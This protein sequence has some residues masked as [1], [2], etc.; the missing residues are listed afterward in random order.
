MP[1][2]HVYFHVALGMILG[3]VIGFKPVLESWYHRRRLAQSLG[4]WILWTYVGG[5]FAIAPS[6]CRMVHLPEAFC[7]GWWMNIFVF[8][9]LVDQLMDKR[10]LLI[11]ELLIVGM[12]GTQYL[13]LLTAIF[14]AG[15]RKE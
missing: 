6:L 4:R 3:A 12:F 13:T 10:G 9:P 14:H 11:G 15:K 2:A 1:S 7:R 5:T 8:H